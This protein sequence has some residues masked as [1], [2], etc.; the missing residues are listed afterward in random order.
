VP[1]EQLL[2][3]VDKGVGNGGMEAGGQDSFEPARAPSAA[4]TPVGQR[5][6]NRV[7]GPIKTA[8]AGARAKYLAALRVADFMAAAT[9]PL[10]YTD[11]KIGP[12][13]ACLDTLCLGS[14]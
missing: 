13:G 6:F 14:C 12:T 9:P 3:G 11:V 4:D 1:Y 7:P 10:W 8:L 2:R 5:N